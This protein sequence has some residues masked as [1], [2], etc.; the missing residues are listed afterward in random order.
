M[1]I[2]FPPGASYLQQQQASQ[3]RYAA[4]KASAPTA[5]T[6]QP[7]AA[8]QPAAQPPATPSQP[9]N[10]N[11]AR[12]LWARSGSGDLAGQYAAQRYTNPYQGGL[13]PTMP[14]VPRPG[15]RQPVDPGVADQRRQEAELEAWQRGGYDAVNRQTPA[16][17]DYGPGN[18]GV[19]KP[20]YGTWIGKPDGE[21]RI[22]D[23]RDS[24]GDG[25]DDRTQAG[26]GQR[27][28]NMPAP[29]PGTTQPVHWNTLHYH[30]GKPG[31]AQPNMPPSPGTPYGGAPRVNGQPGNRTAIVGGDMAISEASLGTERFNALLANN[32]GGTGQMPPPAYP[33]DF[34]GPL[35]G[36]RDPQSRQA[37]QDDIYNQLVNGSYAARLKNGTGAGQRSQNARDLARRLAADGVPARYFEQYGVTPPGQAP[38]PNPGTAQPIQEPSQGTPYNPGQPSVGGW[39]DDGGR[40]DRGLKIDQDRQRAMQDSRSRGATGDEF[41]QGQP[42]GWGSQTGGF[43]NVQFPTQGQ[44]MDPL[45]QMWQ[46]SMN[47]WAMPKQQLL[48]WGQ[49]M[50]QMPWGPNYA[51]SPDGRPDPYS[52]GVQGAFGNSVQ[53][54]W[55]NMGGFI[56]SVNNQAMQKPVG[57]YQGQGNPGAQYGKVNYD[58]RSLINQGNQMVQNGWQNP[59]MQGGAA[60]P[61]WNTPSWMLQTG[62][63]SLGYLQ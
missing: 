58:I 52:I 32:G 38:R 4:P 49:Q 36:P 15:R 11:L 2:W 16:Y 33:P 45:Q 53:D 13:A 9:W 7:A 10:P 41:R 55:N 12:S 21:R 43:P 46:Q 3:N 37:R 62:P 6:Q 18:P 44:G 5:P 28:P 34:E 30:M 26:P 1:T 61:Q 54:M 50:Q 39:P 48:G 27:P 31:A 29:R 57:V 14:S 63:G 47:A 60:Q 19:Q 20:Q 22:K 25:I 8:S 23:F 59:F 56:Q 51:N 40:K 42:G 35:P 24:D 17:V